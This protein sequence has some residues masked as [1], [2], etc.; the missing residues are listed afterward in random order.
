LIQD[1]IDPP[2]RETHVLEDFKEECPANG[3][4]GFGDVYHEQDARALASV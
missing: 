3:V 1:P 4:E 2:S